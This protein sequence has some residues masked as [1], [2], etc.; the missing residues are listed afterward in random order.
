MWIIVVAVV[1]IGGFT[2]LAFKDMKEKAEQ[3]YFQIA[4]RKNGTVSAMPFNPLL[5]A[6]QISIGQD[7]A[8]LV[9]LP[10][11]IEFV[12]FSESLKSH[13]ILWITD[14]KSRKLG[15]WKLG[16]PEFDRHF[17]IYKGPRDANEFNLQFS[18]I[19]RQ[20]LIELRQE[21]QRKAENI[22]VELIHIAPRNDIFSI[23]ISNFLMARMGIKSTFEDPAVY[24][25]ILDKC[26]Q[27]YQGF[28][29]K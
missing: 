22:W 21:V 11:S 23:K 17:S 29:K 25:S 1:V 9:I 4:A 14:V 19:C 3:V 16:E 12:V 28:R 7:T 18:Q 13:S 26:V 6:L 8:Y 10:K 27:I 2:F 5:P 15:S 24:E 20:N